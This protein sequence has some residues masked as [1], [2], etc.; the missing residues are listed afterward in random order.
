MCVV[1]LP[2]EGRILDLAT[3]VGDVCCVLLVDP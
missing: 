1:W 3:K 2:R